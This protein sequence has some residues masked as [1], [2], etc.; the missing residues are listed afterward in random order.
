MF[1][2]QHNCLVDDRESIDLWGK[3]G[4]V[5]KRPVCRSVPIYLLQKWT[6]QW[7]RLGTV[8]RQTIRSLKQRLHDKSLQK[9][10]DQSFAVGD[11]FLTIPDQYNICLEVFSPL[12]RFFSHSIIFFLKW[13]YLKIWGH[14]K[15][16]TIV[17][18]VLLRMLFRSLWTFI[19]WMCSEN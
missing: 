4:C 7:E 19:S 10:A 1:F 2:P 11:K 17:W 9:R 8:Q 12:V 18:N 13:W 6:L 16:F 3:Q 14:S 15:I 5:M